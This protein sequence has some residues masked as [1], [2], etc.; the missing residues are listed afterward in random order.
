MKKFLYLLTIFTC[1]LFLNTERSEA[2]LNHV[3]DKYSYACYLSV[4]GDT[5][6]SFTLDGIRKSGDILYLSIK[7]DPALC[8]NSNLKLGI[9]YELVGALTAV[10]EN[11]VNYTSMYRPFYKIYNFLKA[12]PNDY[13]MAQIALWTML[14]EDNNRW[15]TRFSKKYS[16]VD[17]LKQNFPDFYNAIVNNGEM[18]S[19]E[20]GKQKA[21]NSTDRSIKFNS[22]YYN[23]S[24]FEMTKV[25]FCQY[26]TGDSSVKSA[27]NKKCKSP[28][29]VS[30]DSPNDYYED[31]V[32]KYG[33][34]NDY[35]LSLGAVHNTGNGSSQTK[36]EFALKIH[37]AIA[38]QSGTVPSGTSG[39]LGVW[40]PVG[41]DDE[42]AGMT[43]AKTVGGQCVIAPVE[44]D[45]STC[46]TALDHYM[47]TNSKDNTGK[48][49]I[50]D[51]QELKKKF[52]K[53]NIDDPANPYCEKQEEE[54]MEISQTI[55]R[56]PKVFNHNLLKKYTS[57]IQKTGLKISYI[58][59]KAVCDDTCV[60]LIDDLN[61]GKLTLDE[62]NKKRIDRNYVPVELHADGRYYCAPQETSTCAELLPS[63]P[64]YQSDEKFEEF[65]SKITDSDKA[66]HNPNGTIAC[67]PCQPKVDVEK[68]VCQDKL[69]SYFTLKDAADANDEPNE[70]CY[71]AGVAY[72]ID[73][74]EAIGS[75]DKE[76]SNTYCAVYCWESVTVNMPGAPS[77][78]AEPAHAGQMFYWGMG[79]ET[80]GLFATLETQR[81]CWTQPKY[82]AFDAAWNENE[83]N[84][85]NTYNNYAKLDAFVNANGYETKSCDITAD[86]QELSI[87]KKG[88]TV[89]KTCPSGYSKDGAGCKKTGTKYTRTVNGLT[90]ETSCYE[91]AQSD[92]EGLVDDLKKTERDNALKDLKTYIENRQKL[93]SNIEA[94]QSTSRIN[95]DSM[96]KYIA[97]MEFITNEANTLNKNGVTNYKLTGKLDDANVVTTE[98]SGLNRTYRCSANTGG[99]DSNYVNPCQD[100][101]TNSWS[102]K[103]Y[104]TF[105]WTYSGTYSF[106][107]NEEFLFYAIKENMKIVNNVNDDYKPADYIFN[108]NLYYLEGYGF[109]I[110][111]DQ[112]V[113]T[114]D[115]GVSIKD[116]GHNGHFDKIL[117]ETD[118]EEKYGYDFQHGYFCEYYV[119]NPIYGSEC[120]PN[121]PCEP[122][123]LDIIYRVIE[124]AAGN[125][126]KIFPGIEGN[127]RVIGSN[128]MDFIIDQ[129]VKYKNVT[130]LGVIYDKA[131]MYTIELSP[132]NI[133]KIRSNNKSYRE[134][135]KDPYTSYKDEKDEVKI[136][137]TNDQDDSKTC[138]SSYV[139][140]LIRRGVI[141]GDY[142]IEQEGIRLTKLHNYKK[143]FTTTSGTC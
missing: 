66:I 118:S 20:Q 93:K 58:R 134:K 94:C 70:A 111:F 44:I 21:R 69:S 121:T 63:Y 33:N 100:A 128:W 110:R 124:M 56:Y 86:C 32:S 129:E 136:T 98:E 3:P 126:K 52:P 78:A 27:D 42:G 116:L 6:V 29:G 97:S 113:G 40:C 19:T 7:G 65:K 9:S 2:M 15:F 89:C 141:S 92:P 54:C 46:V 62:F 37:N 17:E 4:G 43:F 59:E 26:V 106:Y 75:L 73:G 109:P 119:D 5:P 77:T 105:K 55:T 51:L 25:E 11:G 24:I 125:N 140:E 48:Y 87:N 50:T 41:A 60:T 22:E 108:K 76:L 30:L 117:E 39:A 31:I 143:C 138:I 57:R 38:A 131:P 102:I 80:N 96:Y 103:S 13:D 95:K 91:S 49:S 107:Y 99:L 135:G 23:C 8:I 67:N 10:D 112:Y 122:E 45:C 142:A 81:I 120:P 71:Q 101:N 34:N 127:G 82:D 74:Q 132:S 1:C 36:A 104:P 53:L 79:N 12:N 64:G 133:S 72:Q 130:S 84:I 137:C 18:C 115:I 16:T 85:E 68:A 90:G 83:T 139:T 47:R 61:N 28:V 114:Y 14:S 35:Y 123:G 88:E